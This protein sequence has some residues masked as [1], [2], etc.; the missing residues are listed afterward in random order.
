MRHRSLILSLGLLTTLSACAMPKPQ[1]LYLARH[2]QTPWNRVSRFQGD[3][4]LDSVGYVN[5]FNLWML[6]RDKKIK[7]VYTSALKRTQ[8]TAQLA[9]R[10]HQRAAAQLQGLQ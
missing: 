5:R 8:I 7:A 6:L 10:Q 4:G 2:G 1:T 9:A 3:P